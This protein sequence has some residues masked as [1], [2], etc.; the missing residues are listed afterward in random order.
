MRES[1]AGGKTCAAR[2][3]ARA[4]A[5]QARAQ[6]L[7]ARAA[8]VVHK[9]ERVVLRPRVRVGERPARRVNKVRLAEGGRE[10]CQ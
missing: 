1:L 10:Q 6:S 9:D 5:G 7:T 8:R 2:A 3:H 4:H